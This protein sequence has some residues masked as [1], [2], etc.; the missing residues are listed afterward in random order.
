VLGR[1]GVMQ[2]E[3]VECRDAGSAL[4]PATWCRPSRRWASVTPVALDRNP[5]DLTAWDPRLAAQ[6]ARRA[7]E[8]VARACEHVGLPRPARVRVMRRSL[9]GAAPPA[10]SFMPYPRKGHGFKRVCVHV[11]LRFE[12]A[13]AGPVLLGVGRYFGVGLCLCLSDSGRCGSRGSTARVTS[14]M[15]KSF[16]LSRSIR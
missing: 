9:F 12:E 3:R 2:L 6:A 7:E 11:E 4:D 5:G 10:P 8:I 14:V 1:L 15:Q 16:E 13:V